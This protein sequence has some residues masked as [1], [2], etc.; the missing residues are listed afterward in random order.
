VVG[1][2]LDDGSVRLQNPKDFAES[3]YKLPSSRHELVL[4]PSNVPI[5]TVRF[6]VLPDE[7][8]GGYVTRDQRELF[9]VSV[10]LAV[11]RAG[12]SSAEKIEPAEAFADCETETYFNGRPRVSL[13]DG[14]RSSRALA[15]T[16]QAMVFQLRRP[17]V[18]GP[19]DRLVATVLT[20]PVNFHQ[21]AFLGEVGR[22]RFSVSPLA[23]FLPGT[24]LTGD[25]R[26]AFAAGGFV[27]RA[28]RAP[29]GSP[30]PGD[31]G[32]RSTRRAGSAAAHP[33]MPRGTGR[34]D[35]DRRHDAAHHPGAGPR[36]L[37]GRVG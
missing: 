16:A 18:L 37:A 28:P 31:T 19:G 1:T 11:R 15:R 4:S 22:I 10:T 13:L 12:Q 9:E 30:L 2:S 23:A 27:S 14:W 32:V 35:G 36:Q 26:A 34:H 8:H 6:E 21:R 33:G 25:D 7:S 24:S 3:R 5:S 17:L 29:R 20:A